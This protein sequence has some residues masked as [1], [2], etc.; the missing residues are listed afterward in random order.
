MHQI[1]EEMKALQGGCHSRHYPGYAMKVWDELTAGS[2][3]ST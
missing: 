2:M 1:V 3:F